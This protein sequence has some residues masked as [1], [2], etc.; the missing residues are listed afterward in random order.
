MRPDHPDLPRT[1]AFRPADSAQEPFPRAD[2]APEQARSPGTRPGRAPEPPAGARARISWADTAKG[3]CIL[4]V[5]LWHVVTKHY[6]QIDWR[7]PWPVPG[8]WGALTEQ[9]LPL[10][11]PLFFTI[12]GMFAV[13]AVRRPW[14]VLGRSK[15]ARFFYLYAV[16]L[17][18]HTALL[19]LVPGFDT[20]RARSVPAL[21]AQ[22]T[23]TPSNLWYLY[24][25]ALYFAVAKATRRLPAAVVLGAALVLSAAASAGLL[26]VPGDRGGVYQNLLFFLGGLYFRPHVER[27]AATARRPRL[28]LIG[29]V[30]SGLLVAMAVTGARTWPGV[31]PAVCVVATVLGVTAAALLS[32]WAVLGDGLARIGRTTLPIY[33][34]HMPLLA[35]LHRALV[36]LLSAGLDVRLR[37]PLAVA[38]PVVLTALLVWLCLMLHRALLKLHATWLFDLPGLSRRAATRS[39]RPAPRSG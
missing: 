36:P 2:S 21:L 38:E 19:A 23:I 31:W 3:A 24:A 20:A 8:A 13:G 14:P 6:L 39:S 30:Y 29:L 28:I 27:L 37:L 15:V 11:M 10:R 35:L 18:I 32:R 9:L 4:L 7:L 16:W 25:L 5:V 33:V 12:S 34:I 1:G 22:L 17:L 26:E